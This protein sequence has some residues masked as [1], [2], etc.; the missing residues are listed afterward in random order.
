MAYGDV[1]GEDLRQLRNQLATA[2]ATPYS[3]TPTP[4]QNPFETNPGYLAALAAE[5][6]GAQQADAALRAAQEA[7]IVGYGDPSLAAALGFN[8]NE[9]T[10]AAARQNTL[11]GNST[12]SRLQHQ[13][14]LAQQGNVNDLAAHGILHSGALGYQAAEI[15]RTYGNSLY[16]AQ[17]QILAGLNAAQQQNL[18]AKTG[19]RN[20]TTQALTSA[21]DQMVQNPQFYGAAPPPP[22]AAPK[23]P[24]VASS[25]TSRLARPPLPNPY[26]TGRKRFG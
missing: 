21:Y 8:V 20:D 10:A 9:N 24:T 1:T 19:L 3:P 2:V 5:Q 22:A 4:S 15:D 11:A 26:T 25:P 17:Q 14:D 13:R 18:Q 12:L 7:A 6:A 23:P 16:D